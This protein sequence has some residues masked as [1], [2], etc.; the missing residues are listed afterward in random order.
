MGSGTGTGTPTNQ[1]GISGL[2]GI[3]TAGAGAVFNEAMMADEE[4]LAGLFDFTQD[5]SETYADI[6]SQ[7]SAWFDEQGPSYTRIE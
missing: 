1:R 6:G 2:G 7:M 4:L 5:L 3:G